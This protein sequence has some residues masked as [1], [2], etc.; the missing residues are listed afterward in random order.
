MYA[1]RV[2]LSSPVRNPILVTIPIQPMNSSIGRTYY[3]CNNKTLNTV[4]DDKKEKGK[5]KKETNSFTFIPIA[6]CLLGNNKLLVIL[7]NACA[8]NRP[9]DY[10]VRQCLGQTCTSII[11]IRE[12]PYILHLSRVVLDSTQVM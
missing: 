4:D 2:S 3:T 11:Y 5:T 7:T 12:V 9:A 10:P 6:Y 8:G 1:I